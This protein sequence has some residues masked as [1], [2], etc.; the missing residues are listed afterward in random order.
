MT[1]PSSALNAVD[2][3]TDVSCT[4][5]LDPAFALVFDSTALGQALLRRLITPRGMVGDDPDYGT[6]VRAFMNETQ[7]GDFGFRLQS[8]IE[9]ECEKDERVASATATVTLNASGTQAS[10]S[11]AVEFVTDASL[12]TLVLAISAVTATLLQAV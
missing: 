7:S 1:S 5:D 9:R 3:G 12:F 8:A 11:V 4:T 2:L 6:D 10:V